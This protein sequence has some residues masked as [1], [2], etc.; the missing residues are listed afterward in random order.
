M[1]HSPEINFITAS[2]D[3]PKLPSYLFVPIFYEGE[4]EINPLV[5]FFIYVLKYAQPPPKI[6]DLKL[7]SVILQILIFT[8]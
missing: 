2:A 8:R 7:I 3:N 4:K 1:T 5:S 6:T